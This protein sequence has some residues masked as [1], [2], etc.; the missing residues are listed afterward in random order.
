MPCMR[1]TLNATMAK[2]KI[3]VSGFR[4]TASTLLNEMGSMES[5]RN[6]KADEV[7]ADRAIILV[8]NLLEDSP[9]A[10][11]HLAAVRRVVVKVRP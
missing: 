8:R 1:R 9:K 10:R 2:E 7:A 3:S 6:R 11:T 5:R 4:A